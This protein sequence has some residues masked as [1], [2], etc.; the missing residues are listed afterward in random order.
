M[1]Q[2]W[3]DDPIIKEAFEKMSQGDWKNWKQLLMEG[4][5]KKNFRNRNEVVIISYQILRLFSKA[6]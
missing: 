1:E 5:K 2:S 6:R 3:A 4:I